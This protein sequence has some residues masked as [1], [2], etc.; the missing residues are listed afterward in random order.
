MPEVSRSE[1]YKALCIEDT[2][3]LQQE[4][5]SIVREYLHD[6]AKNRLSIFELDGENTLVQ[7]LIKRDLKIKD[8]NLLLR[9]KATEP[10]IEWVNHADKQNTDF[11]NKVLE[12]IATMVADTGMNLV[13]YIQDRVDK[14]FLIHVSCHDTIGDGLPSGWLHNFKLLLL[15]GEESEAF[16]DSSL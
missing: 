13:S 5:I 2:T 8:T 15:T 9:K 10:V 11:E 6:L 1:L 12:V 14:L 7:T 4:A 16:Y 3:D